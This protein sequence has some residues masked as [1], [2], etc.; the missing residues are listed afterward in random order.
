MQMS[1][2]MFVERLVDE[3]PQTA[4]LVTEHLEDNDGELLLHL[5]MGDLLRFAVS[6]FQANDTLTASKVLGLVDQAL[7]DGDEY[8]QN[9]VAVSFVEHSG[10]GPGESEEFLAVWPQGLKEE[11][12]RMHG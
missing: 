12:Q 6:A 4:G 3:V 5:L 10:F 1:R 8:V 2:Q 9:A 7:R 11:R